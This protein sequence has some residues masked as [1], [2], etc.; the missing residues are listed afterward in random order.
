MDTLNFLTL[1][2]IFLVTFS[3]LYGIMLNSCVGLELFPFGRLGTC[4]KKIRRRIATSIVVVNLAPIIFFSLVLYALE[5]TSPFLNMITIIGTF[6]LAMGVFGFYRLMIMCIVYDRGR[7][8]YDD[9][10]LCVFGKK[11]RVNFLVCESSTK[12]QSKG[13]LFYFGLS[14]VGSF[15][16]FC[17][18]EQMPLLSIPVFLFLVLCIIVL[19]P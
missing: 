7:W 14:T 19:D 3:I 12:A 9:I 18:V 16:T 10:T 1:S 15:M 5:A 13:V 2:E 4:C 17:Q 6:F 8:F 11:E